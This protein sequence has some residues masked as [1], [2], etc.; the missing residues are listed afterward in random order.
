MPAELSAKAVA[1]LPPRKAP[2]AALCKSCERMRKTEGLRLQD[3]AGGCNL[4]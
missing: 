4:T 1:A 3:C 2:S